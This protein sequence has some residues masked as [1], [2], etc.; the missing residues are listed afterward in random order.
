MMIAQIKKT[1]HLIMMM[2][3]K[4]MKMMIKKRKIGGIGDLIFN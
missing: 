4:M 3:T 2:K 1:H